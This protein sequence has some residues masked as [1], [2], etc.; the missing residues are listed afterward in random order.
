[1][2]HSICF[3]LDGVYF[4]KE[5][6]RR[7]KASLLDVA[8]QTSSSTD[9]RITSSIDPSLQSNISSSSSPSSPSTS[10]LTISPEDID[11]VLYHS[12]EMMKFK[13]GKISEN[14]YWNFARKYL[15]LTVNNNEIF[16]LLFDAYEVNP[17][18]VELVRKVRSQGYQTCICSNNFETRIRILNEKFDFLKDFDVVV[19]SYKVGVM[20]PDKGIFQELINRCA[21]P[22]RQIVYSDDSP[23][24]LAGAQELRITNFVFED[25][26]QFE[27]KLEELGVR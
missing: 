10:P 25:V 15:G 18:V 19:L 3:D 16:S 21:V 22:P 14:D 9:S 17:Q 6:F 7:F 23:E 1:M 4:T 5:S 11:Q 2:I 13:T 12:D 26:E 27:R 20:K 8:N 24:K